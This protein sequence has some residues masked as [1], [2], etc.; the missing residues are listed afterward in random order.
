MVIQQKD[1]LIKV[2]S[3]KR[4]FHQKL[5]S[6]DSSRNRPIGQVKEWLRPMSTKRDDY[7]HR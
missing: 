3:E 7:I 5:I 2:N 6:S 4:D 1:L